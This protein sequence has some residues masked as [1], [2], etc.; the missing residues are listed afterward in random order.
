MNGGL[1]LLYAGLYSVGRFVIEIFRG[2]ELTY[3]VLGQPISAAQAL[4]LV[5]MLA[6]VVLHFILGRRRREANSLIQARF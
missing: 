6:A 4:S 2:D 1:F 5:I 3:R